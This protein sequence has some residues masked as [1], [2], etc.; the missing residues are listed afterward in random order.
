MKKV[1][2]SL[3]AL[4]VGITVFAIGKKYDGKVYEA[5]PTSVSTKASEYGISYYR[6][7]TV[8]FFRT[9]TVIDKKLA[10]SD[11][12]IYTARITDDGNLVDAKPAKELTDLGVSGT[13]A[14]DAKKDKIYFTK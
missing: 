10:K 12:E 7:N 13:F 9:D 4:T 3:M 14:Y 6:N 8:A 1:I 2:L 11:V 5:V